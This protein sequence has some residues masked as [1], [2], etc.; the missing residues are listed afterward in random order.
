MYYH[1]CSHTVFGKALCDALLGGASTPDDPFVTAQAIYDYIRISIIEKC[2]VLS[3]GDVQTPVICVPPNFSG[4]ASNPVCYRCGPPATPFRPYGEVI[5]DTYVLL[6]WRNQPFEG[7]PPTKYRISVRLNTRNFSNWRPLPYQTGDIV[8]T[9]FTVRRLPA[10]VS[11]QFRVEAFNSGGWSKPSEPSVVMCPGESVVPL[12]VQDKWKKIVHGGPLC[13]I[14]TLNQFSS[15]RHEYLTGLRLL[16]SFAQKGN[17]FRRENIQLKAAMVAIHAM[18]TFE[19]DADI[20]SLAIA[21]IGYCICKDEVRSEIN[22]DAN[23]KVRNYCLHQ[24]MT[25]MIADLLEKF[26]SDGKV[27]GAIQW[28]RSA[29]PHDIPPIP[30]KARPITKLED[31]SDGEEE[32]KNEDDDVSYINDVPSVL[33]DL[34]QDTLADI[35]S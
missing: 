9:K 12:S 20:N 16:I 29:F 21:L 26:R 33:Q 32:E 2:N 22:N 7:I 13:I 17:G 11:V 24:D 34:K 15:H 18:K 25:E 4:A 10:G 3:T 30:P 8:D 1:I 19:M 27:L 31:V 35:N 14:D 28:L 5:G 6:R 23:R